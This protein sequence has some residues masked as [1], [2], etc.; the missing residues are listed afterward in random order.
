ML[1]NLD[2]F[3]KRAEPSEDWD[4]FITISKLNPQIAHINKVLFQWN[5]SSSSQSANL[6]RET[7]ALDYIINKHASYI[8]TET[9]TFN[10]SLQFRK[11]GHL[12]F[13]LRNEKKSI[14]YYCKARKINPYSIKNWFFISF[15]YLPNLC[16]NFLIQ[17]IS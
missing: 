4:F 1:C 10:L 13:K 8:L 3:D 9:S 14:F 7:M 2:S 5:L 6:Q 16:K 17:K 15:N 12:Y 11:L